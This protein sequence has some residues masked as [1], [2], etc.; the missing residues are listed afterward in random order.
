MSRVGRPR[1]CWRLALVVIAA[2]AVTLPAVVVAQ[3]CGAPEISPNGGSF[4]Q[5][6]SFSVNRSL[7][8]GDPLYDKVKIRYAV[9]CPAGEC[10]VPSSGSDYALWG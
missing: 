9:N 6:V 7:A 3:S 8:N 5:S 10:G 2:L 4:D 1:P